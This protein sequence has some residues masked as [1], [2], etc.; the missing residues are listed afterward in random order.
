MAV[1]LLATLTSVAAL[2]LRLGSDG[3]TGATAE[4]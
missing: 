3:V 1:T 4:G 2:L